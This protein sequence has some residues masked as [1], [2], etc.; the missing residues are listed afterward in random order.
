MAEITFRRSVN[1]DVNVNRQHHTSNL[2]NTSTR[3]P[4]CTYRSASPAY[5]CPAERAAHLDLAHLQIC[6]QLGSFPRLSSYNSH[7]MDA[8]QSLLSLLRW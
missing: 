6:P 3:S 5:S 7:T 8:L 2:S 1:G 4:I